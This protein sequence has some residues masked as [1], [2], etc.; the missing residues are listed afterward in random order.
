MIGEQAEHP[1]GDHFAD[2]A[3]WVVTEPIEEC[4]HCARIVGGSGGHE[5]RGLEAQPGHAV[6]E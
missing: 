3:L 4:W 1:A 6:S 5:L 2:F